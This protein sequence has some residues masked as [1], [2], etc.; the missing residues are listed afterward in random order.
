L[1][2][3]F[4]GVSGDFLFIRTY[5]PVVLFTS[6]G[7]RHS[8]EREHLGN[9]IMPGAEWRGSMGVGLSVSPKVTLSARFAAA[10]VEE[11]EINDD[12]VEG[13]IQEPMSVRLAATI[14]QCN[15]WFEPFVEF[16]TNDDANTTVFGAIYT[17]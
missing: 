12:R 17:Y 13:T 15:R 6:L 8:F 9:D 14:A 11:T 3:G 7:T 16:G 4:W 1:G 2:D 10:Y 5:D